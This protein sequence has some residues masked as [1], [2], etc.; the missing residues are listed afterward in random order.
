MPDDASEMTEKNPCTTVWMN[1]RTNAPMN[2]WINDLMDRRCGESINQ[3]IDE[4]TNEQ[5]MTGWM[6]GWMSGM[7]ELS[8]LNYVLLPWTSSLIKLPLHRGTSSPSYFFSELPLLWPL[9]PHSSLHTALTMPLVTPAAIPYS[10][11]VA[12][13]SKTT[14]LSCCN[15]LR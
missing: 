1:Q 5:W 11:R 9:Q 4:W 14:T 3:W 2:R 15:A 6:G 8:L 12:L 10:T 7:S 13:W